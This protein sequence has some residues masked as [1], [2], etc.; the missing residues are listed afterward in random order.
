MYKIL[1]ASFISSLAKN[2]VNV[3]LY[4]TIIRKSRLRSLSHIFPFSNTI[5]GWWYF[6]ICL[7]NV[8]ILTY[9]RLIEYKCIVTKIYT[10]YL[11]YTLLLRIYACIYSVIS[12]ERD[13]IQRWENRSKRWYLCTTSLTVNKERLKIISFNITLFPLRKENLR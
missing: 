13:L 5:I 12:C 11:N 3:I 8:W 10:F 2:E 1:C 7:E 4:Y 9:F 6:W